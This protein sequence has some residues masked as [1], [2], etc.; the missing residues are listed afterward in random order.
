MLEFI[1]NRKKERQAEG[2]FFFEMR[3]GVNTG[4]VVSGVVG[5]K[6]FQFDI[7]GDTV[8]IASHMES[9][10]AINRMNVS[11]NTMELIKDEF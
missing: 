9:N 7:W 4:T 5:V 2:K 8:N 1:E 6:N 10:G 3:V 11:G